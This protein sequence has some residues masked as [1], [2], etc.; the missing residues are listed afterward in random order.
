MLGQKNVRAKK[1][2]GKKMV[3]QKLGGKVI[4]ELGSAVD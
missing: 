4:A 1:W 3:G 2:W